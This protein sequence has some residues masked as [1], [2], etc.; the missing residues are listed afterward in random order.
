M[1]G[2]RLS[3][4][5]SSA[6]ALGRDGAKKPTEHDSLLSL[7]REYQ[8]RNPEWAWPQRKADSDTKE[9]LRN[10]ASAIEEIVYQ[11]QDPG[12]HSWSD[13]AL[14]SAG[15]P[16]LTPD[17]AQSLLLCY[18]DSRISGGAVA[19]ARDMISWLQEELRER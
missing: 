18:V 3:R 2:D 11:L 5:T 16:G 13:R 15:Q 12:E 17:E 8:A 9:L 4:A 19:V 14:F 6:A 10:F 1:G 7:A